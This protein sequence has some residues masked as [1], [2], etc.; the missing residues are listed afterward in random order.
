VR[1]AG[2]LLAQVRGEAVDDTGAFER[3][4]PSPSG[5]DTLQRLRK[6]VNAASGIVLP[7]DSLSTVQRK[8]DVR[9]QALGLE[10]LDAYCEYLTRHPQRREELDRA[11]E[12]LTTHETYFFRDLPQLQAFESEVLPALH[13]AGSGRRTLTV[14]S[15]GC[16]TGEEA[17]T[18]AMVILRSGLFTGWQ[19][20]VLGTDLSEKALESARRGVYRDPSFRALPDEHAQ[21]FVVV[22]GG[23]A[24]APAVKALCKFEQRNLLHPSRSS[25]LVQVDAIFCRNVLI[26]FDQASRR[27]VV[28]QFYDVLRPGGFL[29]LGHSE[30][31]LHMSTAFELAHLRGDLGYRKPLSAGTSARGNGS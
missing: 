14:W 20:R 21:A 19:V 29:M 24:V 22:P 31:L 12:Q 3:A 13:R 18:L 23:R 28:Q 8:L 6:L 26:Y 11:L 10:N 5:P 16:S 7:D 4:N 30:S 27:R 1:A 25:P 2:T 9:V 15:A 17:Y